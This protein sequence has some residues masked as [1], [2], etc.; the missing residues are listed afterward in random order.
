MYRLGYH[1]CACRVDMWF[2]W[3]AYERL[4]NDT[5]AKEEAHSQDRASR[6][7]L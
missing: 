1:G 4:M 5:L 2:P 6:T 3:M 7:C